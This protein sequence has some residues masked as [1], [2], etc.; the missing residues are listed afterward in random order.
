[1]SAVNII[2]LTVLL[3]LVHGSKD[4]FIKD[5]EFSVSVIALWK[6]KDL[7]LDVTKICSAP[8][9]NPGL[10]TELELICK[11]KDAATIFTRLVQVAETVDECELCANPAC[12]GCL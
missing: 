3:A 8:F 1:M 4:I 10:P 2:I 12:P 5:G 7:G 9:W 11:S 6:L